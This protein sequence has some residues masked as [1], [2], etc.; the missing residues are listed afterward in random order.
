MLF[1]NNSKK[2]FIYYQ[3][4]GIIWT[5]VIFVL[6]SIP[7]LSPPNLGIEWQDKIYHFIFYMAYAIFL[8]RAFYFQNYSFKVKQKFWLHTLLFG[9]LYGIS[10]EIH[11]YFV[12]GRYMEFAD[13]LADSLG[14]IVGV[15][16]FY[17]RDFLFWK[18]QPK[19]TN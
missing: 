1:E 3:L 12:P 13:G 19:S 5:I 6:S 14:V 11:Q 8:A 10:D 17:C 7:S 2:A 15:T 4:P 18:R 9:V 16:L